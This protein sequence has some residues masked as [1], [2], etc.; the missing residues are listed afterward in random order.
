MR[1]ELQALAELERI[2]VRQQVVE[3]IALFD[4]SD[5]K[6]WQSISLGLEND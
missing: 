6:D 2:A 3:P 5:L 1:M 4:Q